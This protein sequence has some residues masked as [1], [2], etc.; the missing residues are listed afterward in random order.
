[1]CSFGF[2][3]EG[4]ASLESASGMTEHNAPHTF[5]AR[6]HVLKYVLK[7]S[8]CYITTIASSV[9]HVPASGTGSRIVSRQ[10]RAAGD[11]EQARIGGH[12][13]DAV[14]LYPTL[15]AHGRADAVAAAEQFQR[16]TPG[17]RIARRSGVEQHHGWVR[18]AWR[19]VLP[20][21]SLAAEGQ[22]VGELAA[23]GRLRRVTGFRDPL[24]LSDDQARGKV[25]DR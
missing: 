15:E 16:D 3:R 8:G 18:V 10:A 9:G 17:I 21:G 14:L 2:V 11:G 1:M 20:N 24:P 22:S 12:K 5:L 7:P 13:E 19:I 25:G 4:P 23:D 6:A